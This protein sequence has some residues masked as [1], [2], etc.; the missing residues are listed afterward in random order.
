MQKIK[1]IKFDII[2]VDDNNSLQNYMEIKGIVTI[3]NTVSF[4]EQ[5]SLWKAYLN[6]IR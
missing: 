5:Y 2:I 4:L 3:K 1:K 6:S